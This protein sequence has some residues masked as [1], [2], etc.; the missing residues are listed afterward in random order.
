MAR[1]RITIFVILIA[2]WT[3]LMADAFLKTPISWV[4]VGACWFW[5]GFLWYEIWRIVDESKD[6]D[7]GS[8]I[9]S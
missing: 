9:S 1:A 8:K 4:T 2:V 5:I 3:Y 7:S 6:D